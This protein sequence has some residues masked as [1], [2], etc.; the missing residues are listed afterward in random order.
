MP[1]LIALW[2]WITSIRKWEVLEEWSYILPDNTQVVIPGGFVFDGASIPRLFWSILS[3]VGLLLIPGL[4]HDYAYKFDELL[5]RNSAGEL[6]NYMENAGRHYWDRLFR[7]VAIQVNGFWVINHIAW[8]ALVAF[9]C[10][11][12]NSSRKAESNAS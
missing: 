8:L 2:R 1:Y 12:W 5:S 10:F 6:E 11:A 4:I 7:D 3:P 9:G